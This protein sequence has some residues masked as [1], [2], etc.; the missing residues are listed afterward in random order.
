MSLDDVRVS[1]LTE[2]G[3]H[4]ETTLG[5]LRG[6]RAMVVDFWHTRCPRCPAALVELASVAKKHEDSG[7]VFVAAALSLAD[8]S[9]DGFPATDWESEVQAEELVQEIDELKA[10]VHCFVGKDEKGALM[11][12]TLQLR[13]VPLCAVVGEDG[14]CVAKG[15]SATDGVSQ[16]LLRRNQRRQ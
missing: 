15:V 2:D 9:G 14:V 1:V 4:K 13:A 11:R 16:L 3:Q 5:E 8:K 7:T 6:E 12:S 10:V